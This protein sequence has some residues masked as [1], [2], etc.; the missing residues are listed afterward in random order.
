VLH[1]A[2]LAQ[3]VRPAAA[4]HSQLE[5]AQAGGAGA[6]PRLA[7]MAARLA[8]VEARASSL[9]H[10][11]RGILSPAL[12]VTDRLLNNP[13][14]AVQRAGQAVVRTVERATDL[15]Q[16]SKL[17]PAAAADAPAGPAAA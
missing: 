9:R 10:D 2:L 14:P 11:L 16:A 17:E 7:A 12:M 3:V 15:I 8:E 1:A 13:D 6:E 5:A 4:L